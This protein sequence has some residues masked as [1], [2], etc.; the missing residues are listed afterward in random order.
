MKKNAW[1]TAIFFMLAL[2]ASAVQGQV[3]PV[4]RCG[5]TY[6]QTPCPGAVSVDTNDARSKTQKQ[7][8]Q[9]ATQRDKQLAQE[10]EESR[11]KEEALAQAG[12]TPTA[13]KSKQSKSAKSKKSKSSKV[14]GD[15]VTE[16]KAKP[17]KK[18]KSE[19][20][21][22]ASPPTAKKTKKEAAPIAP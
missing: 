16:A 20:F 1:S 15:E 6:S 9:K 10:L 13:D 18:K 11:K 8:S 4:Y 21:T 22:A 5:Q 3:Q 12:S 19:F 2:L 14:S 17:R 7:E